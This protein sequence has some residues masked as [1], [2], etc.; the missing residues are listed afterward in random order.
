MAKLKVER[1][2]SAV[3]IGCR[4]IYEVELRDI[5]SPLA[6][7]EWVFHL[8]RK[9]WVTPEIIA[10]FVELVARSKGWRLHGSIPFRMPYLSLNC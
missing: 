4:E 3:V 5:E 7:M 9:D 10:Q 8:S 1:I 2:G 6:L